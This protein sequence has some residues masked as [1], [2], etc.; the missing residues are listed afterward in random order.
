VEEARSAWA[1]LA[2]WGAALHCLAL[3]L[4]HPLPSNQLLPLLLP[5]LGP[6]AL[7]AMPEKQR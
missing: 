7:G 3:A 6:F 4:L 1:C 5:L 2:L